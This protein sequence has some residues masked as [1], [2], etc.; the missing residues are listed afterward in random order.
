MSKKRET[1]PDT[2]RTV[3]ERSDFRRRSLLK[4]LGAGS[5]SLATA[6]VAAADTGSSQDTI[7][8]FI[9]EPSAQ[10]I[11]YE[12]VV[13]RSADGLAV[14][15][16]NAGYDSPTGQGVEGGTW[17]A[18]DFI[19]EVSDDVIHAGGTT[20]EGFGDAFDV[21]GE[22]VAIW[23]ED[24]DQM[25]AERDGSTVTDRELFADEPPNPD[26]WPQESTANDE[27]A[28]VT[29]PANSV[30]SFI[31]DENA[32]S[33]SHEMIVK[34]SNGE[35]DVAFTD[36]GYDSPTGQGIEGGTWPAE[37]FIDQVS[38]DVIHAG[39]AT[40]EGF[41]DAFDVTGEVVAVWLEDA[42]LMWVEQGGVEI[43]DDLLTDEPLEP[44]EWTDDP[45]SASGPTP[46]FVES[47]DSGPEAFHSGWRMDTM[48]AVS[49]P[50]SPDSS[51]TALRTT[52]HGGDHVGGHG[53]I[54]MD[55]VI[56]YRP[57]ELHQRYWVYFGENAYPSDDCKAPG[58]SGDPNRNL[59]GTTEPNG[60]N[61][62]SARGSYHAT[63]GGVE[64]GYYVYHADQSSWWGTYDRWGVTLQ[65]GRWYQIDQYIDL[66]T[67]GR[68][69]GVL[70]GWVD[71]EEV[72]SRSNWRWRETSDLPVH[73]FWHDFYHGGNGT[74]SNTYHIYTDEY[75][76]WAEQGEML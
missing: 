68:N 66:N 64:P 21:T 46:D 22:V 50:T 27:T 7:W 59:S 19:D 15:F 34:P 72:Y 42:D 36:A 6:S 25:W 16:A 40:G 8:A 31:T 73:A 45:V 60:Y 18:E 54:E 74:A 70:K 32:Q 71:G 1:D 4:L 56:G 76:C 69:D 11:S 17:P 35:L 55:R 28:Q 49:S 65:R 63:S 10:T 30:W 52:I 44:S 14:E 24:A 53:Y 37:D 23:L 57:D 3:T 13:Q 20:G 67:P 47:F 48:T 5:L 43:G 62:W 38:D 41:G 2:S 61:G 51:G 9:T 29:E 12:F 58:F 33:L 26:E 39:G 75:Q